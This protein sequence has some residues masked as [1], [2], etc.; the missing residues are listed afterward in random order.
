[1]STVEEEVERLSTTKKKEEVKEAL[2]LLLLLLEVGGRK[3]DGLHPQQ[4]DRLT[5][6]HTGAVHPKARLAG[7]RV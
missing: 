3:R 5:L 7:G 2:L 1:M 6:T 4:G